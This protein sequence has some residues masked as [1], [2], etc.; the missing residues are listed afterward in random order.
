MPWFATYFVNS[1]EAGSR[2][3]V[4][5]AI[6]GAGGGLQIEGVQG[7]LKSGLQLSGVHFEDDELSIELASLRTTANF[8]LWPL[9]VEIESLH[10]D[11]LTAHERTTD[12]SAGTSPASVE[13]VLEV[14]RSPVLIEV[15]DA[16]VSGLQVFGADGKTVL[17]LDRIQTAGRWKD[18][19]E[20]DRFELSSPDVRVDS[21]GQIDLIAPYTHQLAMRGSL[22]ETGLTAGAGRALEFG[23]DVAGDAETT[24]L[25]LSS[26]SLG[27]NIS[28]PVESPFSDALFKLYV[29]VDQLSW[30]GEGI[31]DAFQLEELSGQLEGTAENYHISLGA[32][33]EAAG[34]ERLQLE[35]DGHGG[36][37]GL[38]VDHLSAVAENLQAN[39]TGQF[40]W[41]GERTL[42]LDLDIQ[43]AVPMMG[44]VTWPGEHFIHGRASL[45]AT[46]ES[47]DLR[48][49]DL[50]LAG[51]DVGIGGSVLWDP[52]ADVVAADLHWDKLGWP[53]GV[54]AFQWSSR[55]GSLQISGSPTDWRFEG[56]LDFET[57]LYQGGG[58]ELQGS[59]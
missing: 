59:G 50:K 54:G 24:S 48:E 47:V 35:L 49:L 55:N 4:N 12:A 10:A 26:P 8:T 44:G 2:W 14:L 23:L 1:T 22:A 21:S 5:R 15:K 51:T 57:A 19:L 46:T 39:A 34:L 37:K 17:H 13:D 56:T 52:Q 18:T 53:L 28:G 58:F 36:L 45:I 29:Q 6:S 43:R 27:L 41:A 38:R 16:V 11:R 42:D 7:R 25:E 20:L 30:N 32:L 9:R 31:P 3:L 33:L 40:R